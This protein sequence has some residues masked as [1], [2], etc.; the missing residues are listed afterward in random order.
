M[1]E[2]LIDFINCLLSP[3]F[4]LRFLLAGEAYIGYVILSIKG[5]KRPIWEAMWAPAC[6]LPLTMFEFLP[7]DL[8]Y[9]FSIRGIGS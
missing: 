1:A 5:R 8:V 9:P 3:P 6:Q 2:T 4:P 7:D